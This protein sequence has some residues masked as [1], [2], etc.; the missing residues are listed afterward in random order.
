MP[1]DNRR[2]VRKVNEGI[3]QEGRTLIINEKDDSKLDWASIP[4][5]TLKVDPDT[6]QTWVKV[7]GQSGWIPTNIKNDGTVSIAKDNIIIEETFTIKSLKDAEGNFVYVN[8]DGHERHMPV[9]ENG[10]YV[11]EL[12]RGSYLTGRNLIEVYIDDL[13]HRTAT[14]GGLQE[15][16]EKRFAIYDKL[17]EGQEITARYS[18]IVRIGSP[19]PRI[20]TDDTEPEAAEIGDIWIDF[21]E[22]IDDD[23]SW[24]VDDD[25]READAGVKCYDV[26]IGA[27]ATMNFKFTE[28]E[29]HSVR[30]VVLD[31]DITSATHDKWIDGYGIVKVAYTQN[32]VRIVNMTNKKLT[33]KV[34]VQT[35]NEVAQKTMV[36]ASEKVA[37]LNV[38]DVFTSDTRVMVLDDDEFS[39]TYGFYVK[40]DTQQCTVTYKDNALVIL[41]NTMYEKT[42]KVVS[43]Q[44]ADAKVRNVT[45]R[46]K[47]DSSVTIDNILTQDVMIYAIDD[48][49]SSKT[50]SNFTKPQGLM[51]ITYT[52][53]SISFY[54]KT[55]NDLVIKIVYGHDDV[56]SPSK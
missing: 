18:R 44:I 33:S 54:N 20:F 34:I 41:N 2:G 11:F 45:V 55:D 1:T 28:P 47:T 29:K 52:P 35:F 39:D 25:D 36:I 24:T 32:S 21:N 16:S 3:T 40:D 43:Q 19:Y 46:P 12:E 5:G 27:N 13:L 23:T 31:D 53:T 6:G 22:K 30:V 10:A 7:R 14:S 42:I 56:V 9:L 37:R 8:S 48:T 51:K 49:I 15:L 26:I 38:T 17:E 4:D 50:G